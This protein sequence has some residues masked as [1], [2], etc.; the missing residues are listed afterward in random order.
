[1]KFI[2][3]AISLITT[4]S[5]TSGP[6]LAQEPPPSQSPPAIIPGEIIVKFQ[7][8]VGLL[9]AQ[10]SLQAQGLQPLET[11]PAGGTIHLI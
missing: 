11:S 2:L 3:F 4:L 10:G 9:A 7:P 8:Q 6:G 5:L 1:M